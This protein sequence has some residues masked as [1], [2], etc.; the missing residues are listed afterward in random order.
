MTVYV[1]DAYEYMTL[2]V[3][4]KGN[5]YS[6][7]SIKCLLEDFSSA[8]RLVVENEDITISELTLSGEDGYDEPG[9][10]LVSCDD[11]E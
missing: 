10:E 3:V 5:L 8:I 2:N 9:T 1:F 6:D 7:Y 11:I 4:Y